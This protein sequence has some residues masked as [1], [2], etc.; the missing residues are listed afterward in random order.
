MSRKVKR[1]VQPPNVRT[2]PLVGPEAPN[3]DVVTRLVQELIDKIDNKKEAR[4]N[5]EELVREILEPE[6]DRLG[7]SQESPVKDDE[8][9][10][11]ASSDEETV[12]GIDAPPMSDLLRTNLDTKIELQRL[13]E[14][15]AK[16]MELV[17]RYEMAMTN[18]NTSIAAYA[19]EYKTSMGWLTESYQNRLQQEHGAYDELKSNHDRLLFSLAALRDT[20]KRGHENLGDALQNVI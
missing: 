5:A 2:T 17:E 15:E 16:T 18:I 4:Q 8:E 11:Y 1:G 20:L 6:D 19:T 3:I 12:D 10:G 13:E 7:S 14:V 9:S